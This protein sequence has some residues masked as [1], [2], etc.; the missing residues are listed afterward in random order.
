[1]LRPGL[2]ADSM[3]QMVRIWKSAPAGLAN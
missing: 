3:N 1:M 2:H